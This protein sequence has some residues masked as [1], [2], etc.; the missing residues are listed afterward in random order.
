M[1]P[2]A[3]EIYEVQREAQA[4]IDALRKEL[5]GEPEFP[6]FIKEIDNEN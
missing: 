6:A 5:L 4:R 1:L 3:K 2:K